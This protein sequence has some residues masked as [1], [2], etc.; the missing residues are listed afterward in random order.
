M[1]ELYQIMSRILYDRSEIQKCGDY[2]LKREDKKNGFNLEILK[3][4]KQIITVDY[5]EKGGVISNIS[6]TQEELDVVTK[7][8]NSCLSQKS[9]VKNI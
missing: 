5:S 1:S 7:E 2:L 8:L 9:Y 4:N 3:D 6:A